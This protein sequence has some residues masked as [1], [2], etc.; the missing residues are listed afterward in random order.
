[1]TPRQLAERLAKAANGARGTI[2]RVL[3]GAALEMEAAGKERAGSVLR[4]RTGNLRR[5]IQGRVEAGGKDPR[6]T[7]SAGGR[8]GAKD[9]VYA[10]THE[11]GAVIRP[12]NAKALRIPLP[13]GAALTRAGVDRYATPL[14]QTAGGMFRLVK[15]GGRA[16]LAKVGRGGG[17]AYVLVQQVK[18]PARP[19]LRPGFDRVAKAIPGRLVAA[20]T[21]A[22]T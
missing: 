17:L 15:F 2:T 1:M 18:I 22:L 7:L 5:S 12:K 14:R 21:E 8:I 19:Y 9:V 16:F 6:L 4:V 13:G 3:V 11:F 10:A 20:L